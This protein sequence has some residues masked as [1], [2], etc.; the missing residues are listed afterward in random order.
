MTDRD[1]A[2]IDVSDAL[3]RAHRALLLLLLAS[4]PALADV[5]DCGDP[6]VN[7][8]GPFDYR[9]ASVQ[10]KQ[11]VENVHFTA[12]TEQLKAGSGTGVVG[13]DIGY[14]LR[15]FPNHPRALL[16]LSRLATREKAAIPRNAKY[17]I[18]CYFERAT[19][20]R[21][22]D[23]EVYLIYGVHTLTA[24][25]ARKAVEL[26]EKAQ[27]LIGDSANVQYNLGLAYFQQKD[28]DKAL[29]HAHRA[30][31]L[32]FPLPGLR[33][34]LQKAGKWQAPQGSTTSSRTDRATSTPEGA[35]EKN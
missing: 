4:A 20:F 16:A 25:D 12:E 19:R 11:I 33:N 15:V 13:G 6:F 10:D 21:P 29:L 32:G 22:D 7:H 9:T 23:G 28:F 5:G 1:Y 17:S 27:T 18:D 3:R 30:Y 2:L 26:L 35:P 8:F 34:M 14:T 24:G 31:A